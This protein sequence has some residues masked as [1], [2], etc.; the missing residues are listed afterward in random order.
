MAEETSGNLLI[1]QAGL[2]SPGF[3]ATLG[4]VVSE[5]LNHEAIEEIYGARNSLQGLINEDIIDLAEESQQ[6]I[7]GLRFTPGIALGGGYGLPS[8]PQEW[9]RI[10]DV[11]QAHNIRFVVVIGGQEAVAAAQE[12]SSVATGSNYKLQVVVSPVSGNNELPMTDHC[13]GF[14]TAAK[15]LSRIA[16]EISLVA[17]VEGGHNL[18]NIVEVEGTGSGWA[19]AGST[20]ARRRNQNDDPPHIVLMPECPFDAQRF[21]VRVQE[22][23]KANRHCLVF[24]A[25]TIADLDGNYLTQLNASNPLS[26]YSHAG[27]AAVL[28]AL[29]EQNIGGLTVTDMKFSPFQPYVSLG[30]SETDTASAELV[31]TSAVQALMRGE[32]AKM[33]AL[34]RS[35]AEQY[36]AETTLVGLA[37]VIDRLKSIPENW[38]SDDG[39]N[40][41]FQFFKY[42]SPLIQGELEVP[43]EAGLPRYVKPTDNR[44]DREL[45]SFGA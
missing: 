23:L 45:P 37:D 5:A 4:G 24:T 3:N 29:I 18:V 14:G 6:F 11:F 13:P 41:G 30:A 38:L 34:V 22:V 10:V 28:K 7:R 32:N 2:P 1:V 31:G 21:L 17:D 19:V 26:A 40:V 33:V 20:L 15:T 25:S 27:V 39:M 42:A 8:L 35:D 16:K 44:I 9:E 12:I 36:E 43:F